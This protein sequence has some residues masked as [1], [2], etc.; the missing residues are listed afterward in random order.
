MGPKKEIQTYHAETNLGKGK[1]SPG[2]PVELR[3]PCCARRELSTEAL[4]SITKD[5]II[6]GF[7]TMHFGLRVKLLE[8]RSD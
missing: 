6:A 1:K 3:E 7:E 4:S 2:A 5:G 8:Y